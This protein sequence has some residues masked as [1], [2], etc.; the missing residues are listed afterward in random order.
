MGTQDSIFRRMGAARLPLEDADVS[1]DKAFVDQAADTLVNLFKAAIETELGTATG[2]PWYTVRTGT[3]LATKNPVEDTFLMPPT[4]PVM[5]ERKTDFPALFVHRHGTAEYRERTMVLEE[6]VQPWQMHYILGPLKVSDANKFLPVISHIV[7]TIVNE[8]I[9]RRGHPNF[10]AGAIQFV[11]G[12]G[13]L[14]TLMLQSHEFGPAIFA[15][16]DDS[17]YYACTLNLESTE[18]DELIED[19]ADLEGFNACIGVGN[20]EEIVPA[21]IYTNSD[22]ATGHGC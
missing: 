10:E 7:P 21:L 19:F 15:D 3:D 9:R 4:S 6:R 14:S 2:T 16:G 20:F 8:V 22:H 5:K 11:D 12:K 17:T 1:A 18:T 13:K